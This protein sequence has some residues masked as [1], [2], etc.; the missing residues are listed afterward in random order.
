MPGGINSKEHIDKLFQ[1]NM[2]LL[3]KLQKHSIIYVKFYTQVEYIAV[4]LHVFWTTLENIIW[5]YS[6]QSTV[7]LP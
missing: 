3:T 7:S 4:L 2:R 1:T 5:K 6:L